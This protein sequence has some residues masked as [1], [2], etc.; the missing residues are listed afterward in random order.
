MRHAL[1][2]LLLLGL[3]L[4]FAV[5]F[6]DVAYAQP[7]ASIDMVFTLGQSQGVTDDST[8]FTPR[9]KVGVPVAEGISINVQWGLTTV[10][11]AQPA[12]DGLPPVTQQETG[13]LNPHIDVSYALR[14]K[15]MELAFAAGLSLPLADADNPG[16]AGAYEVAM[17]S[18]GAWDPW[19]Y[20]P[21][22]FAF[23]IPVRARIDFGF[24]F[25]GLDG[26]VYVAV[27]TEDDNNRNVQF[28]AQ[29][30]WEGMVPVGLFDLGLR[31]QAVR[32]GASRELDAYLQTSL[33][34]VVRLFLGPAI[35]E[36]L[37]TFNFD[38]PHG[39]AM[40]ERGKWG[41]SIGAGF[42]F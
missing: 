10:N 4:G 13:V 12:I 34:P 38:A 37:F 5:F 30:G 18:V 29:L 11:L 40:G 41:L 23:F 25:T 26:A 27:P 16:R 36:A 9:L 33:V 24:F 21:N 20:Q 19:L 8:V 39:T 14:T 1:R 6:P 3:T 35:L 42:R 7:D 31:L 2:R 28:G 32:V 22:T 15:Q 17:G